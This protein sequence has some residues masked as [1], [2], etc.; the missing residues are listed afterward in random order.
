[1][2]WTPAGA[3]WIGGARAG[4]AICDGNALEGQLHAH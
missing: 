4:A 2:V 1:M 3:D